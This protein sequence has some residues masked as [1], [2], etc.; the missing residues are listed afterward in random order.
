MGI[1]FA[2]LTEREVIDHILGSTLH[3]RGGWVVTANT[4]ILRQ[5]LR[6]TELRDLVRTADL[7]VAD[8]MPIVW[9]SRLQKEPLPERVT[10][11]SLIS[12]LSSAAAAAGVPVFLLGGRDG[13]AAAAAGKLQEMYPG[14]VAGHYSP[15]IGFEHDPVERAA[16]HRAV[17]SFGPAVYFCGFGCPKQER[18][19]SELRPVYH[20]SWFIGSGA[21]SDL[22]V[23]ET[24]RAPLL[25]QRLGL[26]WTFRLAQ[27]P[28]RL[29][30]RY[31]LDDGPFAL[32]MLLHSAL[33]ER[34]TPIGPRR[35]FRNARP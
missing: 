3:G 2:A 24:R 16:V 12:T 13:A 34:S 27:E 9:A 11:S 28:K 32:R 1:E 26:E 4:D 29:F 7:I 15:P 6:S 8:G 35:R 21:S 17:G 19:I 23:G 20:G 5:I 31:V 25:A 18:L 33:G 14:L 30:R 10:G 22:L